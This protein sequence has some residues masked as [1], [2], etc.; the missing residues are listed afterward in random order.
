MT[1]LLKLIDEIVWETLS[2][3]W[4]S[5]SEEVILEMDIFSL[6]AKNC[7]YLEKSSPEKQ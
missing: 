5:V 7:P 3:I 2:S 6:K 4:I 1:V